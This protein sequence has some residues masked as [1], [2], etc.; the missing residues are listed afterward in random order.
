M[1]PAL[2]YEVP[3]GAFEKIFDFDENSWFKRAHV[4]TFLDSP[5]KYKTLENFDECEILTQQEFE[6]TQNTAQ[7]WSSL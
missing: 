7:G 2:F 3:L 6:V 4:E 1:R 5:Q